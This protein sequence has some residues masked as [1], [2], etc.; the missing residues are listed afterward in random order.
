MVHA[1]AII[2]ARWFSSEFVKESGATKELEKRLAV[3][4]GMDFDWLE[5]E[6]KGNEFLAGG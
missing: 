3:N 1:L 6:L 5:G 4:M 2:C